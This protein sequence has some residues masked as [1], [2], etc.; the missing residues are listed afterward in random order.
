MSN[1]NLWKGPA[2]ESGWFWMSWTRLVIAWTFGLFAALIV[3]TMVPAGWP[4][5]A[6]L[7]VI[8]GV[9]VGLLRLAWMAVEHVWDSRRK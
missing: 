8:A 7:A 1:P 4:H 5:T 6:V 9:V 2:D 3:L